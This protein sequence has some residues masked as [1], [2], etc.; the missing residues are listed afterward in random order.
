[1]N[2]GNH[3][4]ASTARVRVLRIGR[5]VLP[6]CVDSRESSRERHR[7]HFVPVRPPRARANL[8]T[9]IDIWHFRKTGCNI[10]YK[11]NDEMHG[12]FGIIQGPCWPLNCSDIPFPVIIYMPHFCYITW[13]LQSG[14]SMFRN[15]TRGFVFIR[16]CR[17]R[18]S[19]SW[20]VKLWRSG[21]DGRSV[22]QRQTHS[23]CSVRKLYNHV[24]AKHWYSWPITT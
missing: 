24:L 3:H 9:S 6:S 11:V 20:L 2:S 12:P 13:R 7:H 18:M 14:L 23:K 8:I 21:E 4:D 5:W 22:F 10:S 17:A 19:R 15:N 16:W 1:M